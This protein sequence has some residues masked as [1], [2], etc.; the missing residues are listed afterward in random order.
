MSKGYEMSALR[1]SQI[2]RAYVVAQAAM[3]AL[4]LDCW[5]TAGG[6]DLERRRFTVARSSNGYIRGLCFARI[7][8][9]P[10]ASR[11]L[12]IPIFVVISPTDE[13]RIAQ[14]LFSLMKRRAAD[15][16]C[17]YMRFWSIASENWERLSDREFCSRWDHGLVYRLEQAFHNGV[18]R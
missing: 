12:D 17:N 6:T 10:V 11:L 1:E 18:W 2:E 15:A 5:R 8:Q 16:G 7:F 4:S 13:D 14:D 3:P 9:H